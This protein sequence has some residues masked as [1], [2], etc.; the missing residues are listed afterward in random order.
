LAG[1]FRGLA[2]AEEEGAFGEFAGEEE[3]EKEWE[4]SDEE[5]NDR[6]KCEEIAG[7]DGAGEGAALEARRD[8]FGQKSAGLPREFDDESDGGGTRG[9]GR[10]GEEGGSAEETRSGLRP[11]PEFATDIDVEH[12]GAKRPARLLAAAA[13]EKAQ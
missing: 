4:R 13:T 11:A 3:G 1:H 6:G 9:D 10:E 12:D 8:D 7:E 2:G 5:Q